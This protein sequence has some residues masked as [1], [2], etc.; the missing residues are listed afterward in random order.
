MMTRSE[1]V[2]E[3]RDW[4]DQPNTAIITAAMANREINR[5]YR[6]IRGKINERNYRF[7]YTSTTVTTTAAT[8]FVDMP[9]DC[10][11]PNKLI[12]SDNNVLLQR[13]IEEFN[14]SLDTAEP[15]RWDVAGRHLVFSP[16]PNS[17]YTYTLYYTYDPGDMDGDTDTPVF[18]PG[19]EDVIAI[20]AAINSKMIRDETVKDMAQNV[21]I[22]RLI[23]LLNAAGSPP[24][25]ASRRVIMSNY[26]LGD[27]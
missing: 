7:Y 10:V 3:F 24:T 27:F 2:T 23:S 20:K 12:D 8:P 9:S 11:L 13:D 15:E 16:I 1:L 18:V 26:D 22:E 4:T 17:T 25:S 5:A 14:H 6:E 21:Y 19:Y